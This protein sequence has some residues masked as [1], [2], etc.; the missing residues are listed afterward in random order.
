[1]AKMAETPHDFN[2]ILYDDAAFPRPSAE[3][4]GSAARSWQTMLAPYT[5]P[6]VINVAL[7][8]GSLKDISGSGALIAAKGELKLVRSSRESIYTAHTILH[9]IGDGVTPS[10]G[11]DRNWWGW[12]KFTPEYMKAYIGKPYVQ[13][14]AEATMRAA[15]L[16]LSEPGRGSLFAPAERKARGGKTAA[17]TPVTDAEARIGRMLSLPVAL[18]ATDPKIVKAFIRSDR[19]RFKKLFG[20][21]QVS[22]VEERL[23]KVRAALDEGD[24]VSAK[25]LLAEETNLVARQL[26]WEEQC[27][28]LTRDVG[29]VLSRIREALIYGSGTTWISRQGIANDV[30][31]VTAETLVQTELYRGTKFLVPAVIGRIGPSDAVFRT[32]HFTRGGKDVPIPPD[33][34]E[35]VQS[36]MRSVELAFDEYN[37]AV[38]DS[39]VGKVTSI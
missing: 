23:A 15:G 11:R 10:L 32:T 7:D 30:S 33:L 36:A 3:D 31:Q 16:Y 22:T 4:E 14:L 21:V 24:F 12:K 8:K 34:R 2:L 13:A 39:L 35:E 38:L 5:K 27:Q 19:E 1:M 29:N 20:E 26:D 17:R 25:R 9:R 37:T 28:Q 18:L 6:G